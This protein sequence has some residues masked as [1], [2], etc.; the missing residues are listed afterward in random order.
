MRFGVAEAGT[1]NSVTVYQ[2][3]QEPI[4][5]FYFLEWRNKKIQLLCWQDNTS[6]QPWG[7]SGWWGA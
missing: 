7:E 3:H 2:F 6:A 1:I 4:S 5:N